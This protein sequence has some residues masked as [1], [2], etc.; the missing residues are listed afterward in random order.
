MRAC[1]VCDCRQNKLQTPL[2]EIFSTCLNPE[3]LRSLL[4]GPHTQFRASGTAAGE[5]LDPLSAAANGHHTPSSSILFAG[6]GSPVK[7]AAAAAAA[8]AGPSAGGGG[9]EGVKGGG[10]SKKGKGRGGAVAAAGASTTPTP[11]KKK[12]AAGGAAAAGS[13]QQSGMK[14]FF[15]TT[16]R[17]LGCKAVLPQRQGG[18]F[19]V[20]GSSSRTGSSG[21]TQPP[22]GK[23]PGLCESCKQEDGKLE[24]VYLHTVADQGSAAASLRGAHTACR[25]CHSGGQTGAVVCENGECPVLYVRYQAERQLRNADH[26]LVRLEW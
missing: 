24:A 15:T 8:A 1:T 7:A 22:E 9:G 19:A 20:A 26:R 21:G 3:Q 16:A 14:Q 4:H 23:D 10:S 13:R 6:I 25:R 11:G 17:C 12:G 5:A 18:M 2:K